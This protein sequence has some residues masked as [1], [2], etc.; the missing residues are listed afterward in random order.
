MGRA[1]AKY[2]KF[3]VWLQILTFVFIPKIAFVQN[4]A[5]V[6]KFHPP[7]AIHMILSGSFGE[8]RSGHLHSG[9]DIKTQGRTGK[10][11]YA[12]ASGYVSRIKVSP[13]GYG[14][15]LYITHP[16][17]L[18]SV[19]GHLSRF[20]STI[21]KFVRKV[22]YA[23]K[24][25]AVNIFP[26]K[27]RF[28]IKKGGIIAYSGN[29]GSSGAPHLHFELREAKTESPV[30][31]L[32]YKGINVADH[33]L[34]KIY[35]LAV[36]PVTSLS[37]VNGKRNK[38]I[39]PVA[40]KGKKC[41]LRN[42]PVIKVNG[43]VAL[44]LQTNDIMDG[45][46]NRNGVYKIS[47][48]KDGKLIFG[49]SMRKTSFYTSRDVN[50]LIDYAYYQQTKRRIIRTQIDT[51]N[52]LKNYF[53]V[54]NRGIITFKDTKVH[55]FKFVVT[56]VY[57]NT[58]VLKFNMQSLGDKGCT[59]KYSFVTKPGN[60]FK[61]S[62]GKAK[63]VAYPGIKLYIPAGAFYKSFVMNIRKTNQKISNI[64]PVYIIQNRYVPVRKS[65]YVSLRV[66]PIKGIDVSKYF[67]AY[68]PQGKW[69]YPSF[70]GGKVK[71]EYITSMVNKLGYYTV[72]FDTAAPVVKP[73]N[74]VNNGRL[75]GK[76][77][78]IVRIKDNIS[79]IRSYRPILNG[80]WILM[81]YDPKTARL[82]YKF[83][84]YI[85]KG[86]NKFSLLVYDGVGNKTN[87]K[88]IFYKH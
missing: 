37:C 18:V 19:Y 51:N 34:P 35:R 45:A 57:H 72:L 41:Y 44:G 7:L 87:Y 39:Y 10:K 24:S 48:Y 65:F 49:L 1:L 53:D 33:Q 42:I 5:K 40:G 64:S 50:S 22:Q 66:N 16:N 6:K 67:L 17:G 26:K 15:A 27:D 86:K 88:A 30:N 76:R 25:F 78:L 79:G 28:K 32:L 69:K 4:P 60:N 23:R 3:V 38:F 80:H 74:F 82:I 71:G 52:R 8:V 43:Q 36:Y 46:P 73:V 12:V 84:K 9:I 85:K 56:D 13:G 83:D 75:K 47:L 11:V 20:N 58:S 29:S 31:P 62:I 81:D 2:L 61:I 59:K 63:K 70:A 14:K 55:H 68:S 21:Q 54:I 77:S